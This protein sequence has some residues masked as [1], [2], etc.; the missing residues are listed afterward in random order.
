VPGMDLPRFTTLGRMP[1]VATA[2]EPP[3]VRL[4][5]HCDA[6]IDEVRGEPVS[7]LPESAG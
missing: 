6:D 3:L 1:C 7:L 2:D 5:P 4:Y